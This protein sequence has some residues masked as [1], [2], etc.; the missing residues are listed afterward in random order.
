[1]KRFSI[2]ALCLIAVYAMAAVVAGGVYAE[3]TPKEKLKNARKRLPKAKATWRK[4][5][6]N[7]RNASKN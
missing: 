7:R 4:K 2:L 5:K 1:M 3:G 6:K